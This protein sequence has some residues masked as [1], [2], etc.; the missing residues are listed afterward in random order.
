MSIILHVA[1]DNL[2]YEQ[3]SLSKHGTLNVQLKELRL[4]HFKIDNFV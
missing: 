1:R 3:F 4:I 2:H